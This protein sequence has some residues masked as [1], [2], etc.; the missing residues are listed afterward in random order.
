LWRGAKRSTT[1]DPAKSGVSGRFSAPNAAANNSRELPMKKHKTTILLFAVF[2]AGLSVLLYPA[3]SDYV[4]S[5]T[6][7]RVVSGY[8]DAVAQLESAD[9]S[10]YLTAASEYNVRL[11]EKDNR[12]MLTDAEKAEYEAILSVGGRGVVGYVEIPRIKVKLPIYHGTNE[13]VLQVGVGHLEGSSFPVGGS[14]S[15]AV[16]TG[17]RG[18][19]SAQLLSNIDRLAPGD[20]FMITVLD[21]L[22]TYEVDRIIVVEPE[23]L[24]PLALDPGGDYVTL[25][26]CTPYGVNSHRLLVRGWRVDNEETAA[27]IRV[28]ADARQLETESVAPVIGAGILVILLIYVLIKY[29]TGKG[30]GE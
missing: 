26:T 23:D 4:N 20:R 24:A 25:V 8:T 14:G 2:L 16:I 19:P 3:V 28:P 7:S 12:F 13:A 11:A 17:H 5:L 29:R 18:L 9:Y 6:Q 27:E 10:A 21:E 1:A 30:R 15:H 22:L